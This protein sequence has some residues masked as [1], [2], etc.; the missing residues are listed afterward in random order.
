MKVPYY[1][2]CTLK[3][4]AKN[5]EDSALAV[6][7][8]LGVELVELPRWNCC[9]TVYSLVTDDLMR[10]IAPVRNLI[11]VREMYGESEAGEWEDG[12][13]NK[14]DRMKGEGRM[15]D[16]KR[17]EG[18]EDGSKKLVTLCSMCFNTLKGANRRV[19]GD[20]ED[21][22][23]IN[24]FMNL[25]EDYSGDVEVIHFLELLREIGFDRIEEEVKRP[26]EGLRLSPYYGCMLLRPDHIAIDD[27][28]RP[29]VLRE[30]TEALGARAADNPREKMCCG[31]YLTV[32][33]KD[34]V[35][36][37]GHDILSRAARAGADAV[38]T[39]C[40]LC[41]F[42]LDNRQKDIR[43]KHPEFDPIPVLYFTQ[44]MAVAFGLDGGS[45]GL[46]G[47]FVDPGPLLAKKKILDD[48]ER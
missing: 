35:V 36:R 29:T 8:A 23:K 43:E 31:S 33:D 37:L 3:T 34:A 38:I 26:L 1:P 9:G 28:E 47:N 16:R 15:G 18:K 5:F 25:E 20:P 22:K 17:G 19:K 10:H 41:A 40:H 42:N 2:G 44:V 45:Y 7:E 30:L 48:Q 24:D 11:R 46:E 6:A 13:G 14:G 27:P 32:K 4:T 12:D 39:S 21:L